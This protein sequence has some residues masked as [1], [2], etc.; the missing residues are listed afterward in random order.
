MGILTN[1]THNR[2]SGISPYVNSTTI[3]PNVG[4][5]KID[6]ADGTPLATLW[7]FAVHGCV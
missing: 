7:N 6:K 4:V 1:V 2:R 3:D 5:L